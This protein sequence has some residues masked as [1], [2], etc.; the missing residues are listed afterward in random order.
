MRIWANYRRILTDSSINNYYNIFSFIIH[1]YTEICCFLISEILTCWKLHET[2]IEQLPVGEP[3]YLPERPVRRQF[4]S[5]EVPL[6]GT[7][8][9]L[10]L[11]RAMPGATMKETLQ[12]S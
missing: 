5:F 4:Q 11:P 3:Q 2:K 12:V 9:L 8:F 10:F 7:I 6:Q 1:D